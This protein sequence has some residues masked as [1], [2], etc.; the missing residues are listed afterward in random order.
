LNSAR[1]ENLEACILPS[2]TRTIWDMENNNLSDIQTN[3]QKALTE[4]ASAQSAY[5]AA[6]GKLEPLKLAA[7]EKRNAV[8]DLIS[9]FQSAIGQAPA[10]RGRRSSTG[11]KRAY[12]ATP[13]SK[14][15]ASGKRAYTRAKNAGASDKD[16]KKAKADAEVA[17]AH[18][19]G[20]NV[21]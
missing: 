20:V 17:L 3:L 6:V 8:A 9:Q 2:R 10:K 1:L 15:A 16:A 19:L 7:E 13:E 18:K 21:K 5:D 4:S 11:P 14:I 12:N